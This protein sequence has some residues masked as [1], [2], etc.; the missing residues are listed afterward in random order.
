MR[1]SRRLGQPRAK[2]VIDNGGEDCESDG[3]RNATAGR[4]TTGGERQPA[5]WSCSLPFNHPTAEPFQR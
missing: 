4:H 1:R 2:G 3:G 5:E